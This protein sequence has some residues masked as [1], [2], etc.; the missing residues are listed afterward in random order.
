MFFLDNRG[1]SLFPINPIMF[2]QIF[3]KT[4]KKN[5][6]RSVRNLFCTASVLFIWKYS[7]F[8]CWALRFLA[9]SLYKGVFTFHRLFTSKADGIEYHSAVSNAY[10]YNISFKA[11]AQTLT[12]PFTSYPGTYDLSLFALRYCMK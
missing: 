4:N 5:T 12:H 9:F 6:I 2:Y 7:T 3:L 10:C 1:T 8:N 11:R